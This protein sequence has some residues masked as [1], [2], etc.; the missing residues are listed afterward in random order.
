[1]CNRLLFGG[2]GDR[3]KTNLDDDLHAEVLRRHRETGQSKSQIV[4][5]L[6]R[7]GVE[8]RETLF[9]SF[10]TNFGIAM[11]VAGG[12]VGALQAVPVG[13][14]MLLFGLMLM[15]FGGAMQERRVHNVSRWQAIKSTLGL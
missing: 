8:E 5:E 13:V 6:V 7:S 2:M 4:N 3:I 12:V 15:L 14:G 10:Y 1:M 11:F 9:E